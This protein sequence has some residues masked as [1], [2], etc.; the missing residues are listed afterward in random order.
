MSHDEVAGRSSKAGPS[1]P[2]NWVQNNESEEHR[3]VQQS[4]LGGA[5]MEQQQQSDGA[6]AISRK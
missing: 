4:V 5:L 2:I 6:V 1:L 3:R